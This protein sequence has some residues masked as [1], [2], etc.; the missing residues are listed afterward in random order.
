MSRELNEI[1]I[2]VLLSL[3]AQQSINQ[4]QLRADLTQASDL[5]PPGHEDRFIQ[6]HK[7]QVCA[8]EMIF[9][10]IVKLQL[11]DISDENKCF[12]MSF[13]IFSKTLMMYLQLND[14]IMINFNLNELFSALH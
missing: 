2:S 9:K 4:R 1:H 10:I 14:R 6:K 13:V 7:Y 8:L 12:M 5:L 3:T 11:I